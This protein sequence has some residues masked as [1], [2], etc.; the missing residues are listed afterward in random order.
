MISKKLETHPPAATTGSPDLVAAKPPEITQYGDRLMVSAAWI[1]HERVEDIL[2]E[3]NRQDDPGEG[4]A[5]P[6]DGSSGKGE[7]AVSGPAASPSPS[8]Q[9]TSATASV[10]TRPT[11]PPVSRSE[12]KIRTQ[13]DSETRLEFPNTPLRQSIQ[14]LGQLHDINIIVD[15]KAMTE[16]SVNIDDN[17]DLV[18][19]GVTLHSALDIMLKPLDLTYILKDEVLMITTTKRAHQEVDIRA[20]DVAPLLEDR[21]AVDPDLADTITKLLETE[22]VADVKKKAGEG[23]ATLPLPKPQVVT[24]NGRLLV[25]ASWADHKRIEETLRLMG[26][27]P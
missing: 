27:K 9:T 17:I 24:Y 22:S 21:N 13:L 14:F 11:P 8:Q 23:E 12:V 3:L 20:Y 7:L 15:E 19:S 5:R 2:R 6:A 25:T 16:A 4:R 26:L 10:A 18:L 1:D